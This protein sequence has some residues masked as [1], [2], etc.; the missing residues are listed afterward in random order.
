MI[1]EFYVQSL[2]NAESIIDFFFIP[3]EIMDIMQYSET[4]GQGKVIILIYL[5]Y[6]AALLKYVT[7]TAIK[8]YIKTH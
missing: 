5:I 7:L 4:W 1:S 2:Q 8:N 6:I 3:L